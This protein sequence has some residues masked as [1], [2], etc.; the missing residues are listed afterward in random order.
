MPTAPFGRSAER[1][2]GSDPA[3]RTRRE[4]HGAR[5]TLLGISVVL[6]AIVGFSLIN[7]VVKISHASA[8]VFSF[9]RLWLGCAGM[10]VVSFLTHRRLTWATLKR[11]TPAGVL[12]GLNILLFFSALKRTSVADVLII[13]ALQPA[14]TLLVAGRMFGERV[15][16]WDIAWTLASVGGVVAV[17][18]GSSGTPVWSLSGDLFAVGSLFA[19]T[20]YFLL[21]KRLRQSLSAIE[22]MTGVTLVAAVVVTPVAVLSSPSLGIRAVDWLWLVVFVVGAQGGHVMLA[23]AHEQ[24]DVS[25]SSLLILAEPVVSAVAAFIV[26][27][28]PLKVLE[29][30]GGL[31]VVASMLVVVWRATRSAQPV[32]VAAPPAE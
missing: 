20:I 22:Y 26:L 15:E 3:G 1:T 4:R 5:G 27:D 28:E 2:P 13:A 18:L 19:F 9:Y 14:L 10:F 7:I 6:A 30:V 29:I 23:W 8:V 12:F 11:T 24:V 31:I 25:V 17:T 21:S 32:E 16:G